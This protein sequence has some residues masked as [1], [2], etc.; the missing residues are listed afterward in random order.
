MAHAFA[1]R[2]SLGSGAIAL[3]SLAAGLK[4]ADPADDAILER[5]RAADAVVLSGFMVTF[6]KEAPANVL[7]PE[8]G[9]TK[10]LC[11]MTKTEGAWALECKTVDKPPVAYRA[12]GTSGYQDMDYDDGNL[13][14]WRLDSL[15]TLVD[16]SINETF[17]EHEGLIV[18]P[19][20]LVVNQ[21]R[22]AIRSVYNLSDQQ[23]RYEMEWC[24]WVTGYGFS[25]SLQS[26]IEHQVADDGMIHLRAKGSHLASPAGI[27]EMTID[28]ENGFMIRSAA[29]TAEGRDSPSVICNTTGTK[30][31][32]GVVVAEMGRIVFPMGPTHKLESIFQF[33]RYHAQGDEERVTRIREELKR[34][35]INGDVEIMDCRENPSRA[36]RIRNAPADRR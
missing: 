28:P 12:P 29:F 8:L 25:S 5:L 22:S 24:C 20:G 19:G 27:W 14:V 18:D 26:V 33:E 30:R 16:G 32:D 34:A 7:L 15:K 35:A 6:E 4:G 31:F 21:G 2:K 13:V 1:K 10:M 9:N 36:K 23:N 17:A 11:S 3:L